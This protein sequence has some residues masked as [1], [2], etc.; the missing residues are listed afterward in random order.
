MQG[1]TRG[2]KVLHEATYSSR[3]STDLLSSSLSSFRFL[4]TPQSLSD[5]VV[6]E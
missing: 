1:V 4:K 5:M 6:S 3:R 2:R